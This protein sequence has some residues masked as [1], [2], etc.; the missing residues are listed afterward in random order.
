MHFLCFIFLLYVKLLLWRVYFTDLF[1]TKLRIFTQHDKKYW[2]TVFHTQKKFF[3]L[4]CFFLI[5]RL[6]FSICSLWREQIIIFWDILRIFIDCQKKCYQ[7]KERLPQITKYLNV[8]VAFSLLT[9]FSRKRQL[10]DLSVSHDRWS[11]FKKI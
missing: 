8:K 11:P 1:L 4:Y 9:I 5:R 6:L 7:N 3:F 2:C 10:N